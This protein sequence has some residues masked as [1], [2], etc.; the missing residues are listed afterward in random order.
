MRPSAR[1]ALLLCCLLLP[2]LPARA[3]DPA[4]KVDEYTVTHWTMKAGLPHDL[5]H[6]ISQDDEGF[7]WL[8]TW[9]GAA[10]FNGR[11]FDAYD[12][13]S[14]PGMEIAGVR[15]VL[16]DADGAMLLGTASGVLRF[17]HGRWQR[18]DGEL[19]RVRAVIA[20][21]RDAAGALWVGTES[22]LLRQ[23][24]DGRID[25][26]GADTGL[27]DGAVFSLLSQP[28][29]DMLIGGSRGLLRLHQ[30][31]LED[32]G[33][34][35]GLPAR[36][37]RSLLAARGGG[38][39]VA[40]D[41]GVW[42]VRGG[43]AALVQQERVESVLEDRD[44]NLWMLTTGDG[45]IRY[46]DGETQTLTTRNGLFGR[47][48]TLFEDREGLL[49]AGTTNGLFRIS[50][51]AVFGL[52]QA[53]GLG[54]D[55]VRVIVQGG[56][57]AVWLGHAAGLDVWRDG[58]LS[59][60]PLLRDG[61]PDPSVLSLAAAGDA[62]V[63]VGTYDRG[64]LRL[65]RNGA[66]VQRIGHEQGLPSPQVRALL[67]EAGGGLWVGT[68]SGLA[69]FRNGR[70][71]RVY[72]REDG[73]A[74]TF[75]RALYRAPDGVLW[76]GT[77]DGLSTLAADGVLRTGERGFPAYGVFDFLGDADGSLWIASDHGLLRWREGRFHVYGRAAGMPR[78]TLFRIL[79]DGNGYLWLSSNHGVF[80]VA[81]RDFDQ[82]DAGRR[83]RLSVET[84]DYSDGMPGSQANGNGMPAGWRLRDGRLWFPTANGVAVIDPAIAERQRALVAPLAIESVRVDGVA[85]PQQ[86]AYDLPAS[87]HRLQIRYAGLN[88]RE[89]GKLRYRYRM[90][91]FEHAWNEADT[92][93]EAVYTNLPPG[94]FRFQVQAT[95]MPADWHAAAAR[96]QA[97][98]VF[99]REAPWWLRPWFFVL[100]VLGVA[101]LAI[102]LYRLGARQML[103]KKQRLE[104]LIKS[105]TQELSDKNEALEQ[106]SQ[107]RER[108]LRCLAWQAS[109][110]DL[111]GL[112]N[113]REAERHLQ[114]QLQ[115][116]NAAATPLALAL[117]DIDHFKRIND[118]YG[119]EVGDEMLRHIGRLLADSSRD[120][121]FA[122]RQG[123]EE[124]L[125]V[126]HGLAPEQARTAFERIRRRI[127]WLGVSANGESVRCTASVGM[128]CLGNDASN[129]RELMTLADRRLYQAKREGRDRMV[130]E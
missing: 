95:R 115:Q 54:D 117:L 68:S 81:R 9:E 27:R 34:H 59:P 21:H 38:Y 20:L 74:G 92:A 35:L 5:I 17:H 60:V 33:A 70:L 107:E 48:S 126:A 52:T 53:N 31:R 55:Y 113:R 26:F 46:R 124:F 103:R 7:L 79:D 109:H 94:R 29:G 37:V 66:V 12:S 19:G 128:A 22:T 58:R 71:L 40:G 121:V 100:V 14:V 111:T 83:A 72:G 42:R 16:R 24:A 84:F 8:G 36:A 56:D 80:R 64:V 118:G 13:T 88:L 50:D 106:A 76:I 57:G 114:Q 4:R 69:H 119:H 93:T 73:L 127:G 77:S 11:S 32:Y 61:G 3:L 28:D 2:I 1:L 130:A 23:G 47:G 120:E 112:P 62:G 108:L 99:E 15:T 86:A 49:W 43:R 65:S 63:W 98:L 45:L 96:N 30:G 87:A 90:E 18:L 125:L 44:G 122:A 10:R 67:E 89:P 123:G 104:R 102:W 110:D 97:E 91:G 51:G 41:G 78:D 39:W 105:R 129:R 25:D 101:L 6:R 82:I 85:M 116:A 75:V